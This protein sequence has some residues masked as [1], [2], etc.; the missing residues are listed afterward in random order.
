[1]RVGILS[2][3]LKVEIRLMLELVVI[4]LVVLVTSSVV[5]SKELELN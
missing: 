4:G 5:R 3:E 1:M 2:P